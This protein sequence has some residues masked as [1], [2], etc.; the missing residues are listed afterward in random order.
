MSLSL[1]EAK[2]RAMAQGTC[3][4]LWLYSFMT[5]LSFPMIA[6]YTLFCD[7][8]SAIMLASDSVLHERTKHIEVD[9]H[10]IR[11]KVRSR[12]ITPSF[13]TS[14]DQTA[15]MFIKPVGPSLLKSPLIKLDL[16]DIF[17]PA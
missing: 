11:E 16:I 1:A 6:P 4:L 13:V 10:F 14:A 17:T 7:N 15:D 9:V 2:Y 8:K 12:M 3:E 5:E